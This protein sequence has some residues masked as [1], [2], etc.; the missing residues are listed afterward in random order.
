M[1]GPLTIFYVRRLRALDDQVMIDSL[2]ETLL[3]TFDTFAVESSVCL[4]LVHN[5]E[6]LSVLLA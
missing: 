4:V 2:S 1:D 5:L 6:S 3:L